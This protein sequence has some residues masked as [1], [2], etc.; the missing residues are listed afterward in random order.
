MQYSIHRQSSTCRV[1]AG[2]LCRVHRDGNLNH[3]ATTQASCLVTVRRDAASPIR[4]DTKRQH[5]HVATDLFHA[6]QV[7]PCHAG[8]ARCCRNYVASASRGQLH[9]ATLGARR[10]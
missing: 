7:Q 10:E 3:H 1:G 8:S 4:L 9:I 6:E 2:V 5:L